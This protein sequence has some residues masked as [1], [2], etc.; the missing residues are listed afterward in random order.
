LKSRANKEKRG[1]ETLGR[2]LCGFFCER[3]SLNSDCKGFLFEKLL[4]LRYMVGILTFWRV[5][6]ELECFEMR[7]VE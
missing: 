3:K 6:T 4:G 7:G 2:D 1:L 5:F